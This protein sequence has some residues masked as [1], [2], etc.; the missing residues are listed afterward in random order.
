MKLSLQTDT[1]K[2]G[3]KVKRFPGLVAAVH[4]AL[5]EENDLYSLQA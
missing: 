4:F 1:K 5:I 2:F 3:F